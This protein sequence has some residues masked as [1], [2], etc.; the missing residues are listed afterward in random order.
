MTKLVL[1][2]HGTLCEGM[3]SALKMLTDNEIDI[4]AV[5]L[6]SSG[7]GVFRG[8]LHAAVTATS[9]DL[10][11]AADLMGGTPCKE[12]TALALSNPERIRVLAGMNL[13]MLAE[14]VIALMTGSPVDE[15][16]V[17][18]LKAGRDGVRPVELPINQ[19]QP[20]DD[21]F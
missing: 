17:R 14:C 19:N 12:A 11:I 18:G 21:L 15:A 7:V 10:I 16:I 2:S 6:G 4:A 9:G 13:P 1:V 3:R 8:Q 5:S 20:D